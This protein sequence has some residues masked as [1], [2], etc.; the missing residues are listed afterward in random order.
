MGYYTKYDLTILNDDD[1]IMDS[2]I[3]FGD[4]D[5]S[6]HL[7]DR[8]KWYDHDTDIINLSLKH[9]DKVFRL[10]GRGED[11]D[12]IWVK[13]YKNGEFRMYQSQIVHKQ[14]SEDIW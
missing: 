1:Y 10:E 3:E 12:D 2:I 9:K 4:L 13:F 5:L 7:S 14:Y 11:D 6:Y 8:C